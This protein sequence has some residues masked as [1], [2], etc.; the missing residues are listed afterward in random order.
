MDASLWHVLLLRC[1]R[2]RSYTSWRRPPRIDAR[3]LIPLVD[4]DLSTMYT[5]VGAVPP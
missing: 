3:L 2:K 1:R 4:G 5:A